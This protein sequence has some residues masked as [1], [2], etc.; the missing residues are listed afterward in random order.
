[1]H[2]ALMPETDAEN[3]RIAVHLL[4]DRI[5]NATFGRVA[6]T[7]RDDDVR[8][9]KCANFVQRYLVVAKD[10]QRRA[11]LAEILNEVVG[12]RIVIVYDHNHSSSSAMR[13]ASANAVA[14][15]THS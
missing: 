4:N 5:G 12:E 13:I 8:G 14:L 6:G 7:G 15:F 1:M 3:R 2:H 10:A 11:E 9:G